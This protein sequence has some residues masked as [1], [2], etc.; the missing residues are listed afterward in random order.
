MNLQPLLDF[1]LDATWQAGRISLGYFQ[2]GVAVERK[3]DNSPVTIADKNAEQRLRQLITQTYPDHAIIGEE[4][5]EQ[6]DTSGLKWIVDPIDGTKSFMSG[7][8]LYGCLMALVEGDQ[9][10]VG[11]A[12]FPALN[13]TVYAARGLGAFWNGRRARVSKQTSLGDS[14]LLMS[15]VGNYGDKTA[16][17][18]KLVSST[19]IQRTWGDSYG[20]L[21]VATGRA[22]I[23]LDAKMA[24]WDCGPFPVIL[25]EA[26]G[27]FTDWKGKSSIYNGESIAT[28]GVL[29]NQVMEIVNRT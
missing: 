22:E 4:F 29:Y 20:Y 1:A 9:V 13:E 8:P 26:G 5:G 24:V 18:E 27:T 17:W 21:L 19:Y 11:V 3:S 6:G 15:D 7:V 28:N 10:L 14:V 2:T 12:H 25:E 23:M 16:A